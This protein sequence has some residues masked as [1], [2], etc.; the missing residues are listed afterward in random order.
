M[1]NCTGYKRGTEG[2]RNAG[3]GERLTAWIWELLSHCKIPRI[4]QP[5]GG[6]PIPR[7][8][9]RA[10]LSHRTPSPTSPQTR[11]RPRGLALVSC[12]ANRRLK[13]ASLV[14]ATRYISHRSPPSENVRQLDSALV[15][16]FMN[17]HPRTLTYVISYA[18]LTYFSCLNNCLWH[19]QNIF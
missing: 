12:D 16:P 18:C 7:P 4:C 10:P 9:A 6:G 14:L 2:I 8:S 13:A 11:G 15:S 5:H 17:E 1:Y 19:N 3:T